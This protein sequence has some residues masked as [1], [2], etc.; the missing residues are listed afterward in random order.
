MDLTALL[1]PIAVTAVISLLLRLA[2][3]HAISVDGRTTIGYGV[4]VRSFA[5][6]SGLVT[7]APL[8]G[9]FFVEPKDR[10][11]MLMIAATFGFP[12]L[13]LLFESFGVRIVYSDSGIEAFSPWRKNRSFA[14]DELRGV[15][16]SEMA[17]WHRIETTRG[18]VRMHEMK[19][20]VA[21]LLQELERRGISIK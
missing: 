5:V 21:S 2:S 12:A 17:R 15:S 10:I 6:L 14:W 11:A 16:F 9:S 1:I 13:Y 18:Y 3:P 4:G 8:V 7:L 19:S 20:G